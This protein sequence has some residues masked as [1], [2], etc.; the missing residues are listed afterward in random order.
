MICVEYGGDDVPK[1]SLHAVADIT[2]P[3]TIR[4]KGKINTSPITI[5]ISTKSITFLMVDD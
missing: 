3:Q 1:I 4:V 2:I 5:L